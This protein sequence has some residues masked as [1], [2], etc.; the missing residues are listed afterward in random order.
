MCSSPAAAT[1]APAFSRPI[2]RNAIQVSNM[3]TRFVGSSM[4]MYFWIESL[5]PSRMRTVIFLF[6]SDG[7]VLGGRPYRVRCRSD[8]AVPSNQ[9]LRDVLARARAKAAQGAPRPKRGA[10]GIDAI[11]PQPEPQSS[12]LILISL[13][14]A[15]TCSVSRAM[16]AALSAASWVLALPVSHT[17]PSLS[18]ST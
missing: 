14:T 7:P 9:W 13:C 4:S 1:Q 2:H 15:F 16:D 8:D 5:M 17:T 11:G 18:V 10:L 3:T 6:D 12:F